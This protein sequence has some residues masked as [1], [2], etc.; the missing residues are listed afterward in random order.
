MMSYKQIVISRHAIDVQ[1]PLPLPVP[2]KIIQLTEAVVATAV[3]NVAEDLLIRSAIM[4]CVITV[5][6][7]VLGIHILPP[8]MAQANLTIVIYR[9]AIQ[10]AEDHNGQNLCP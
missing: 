8:V 2:I 3:V 10:Y 5:A 1:R 4:G 7:V 6:I 9:S